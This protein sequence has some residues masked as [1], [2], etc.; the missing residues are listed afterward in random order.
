MILKLGRLAHQQR[1]WFAEGSATW[2]IRL[3]KPHFEKY[4]NNDVSQVFNVLKRLISKLKKSPK[5]T[6]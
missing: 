1:F 4:F 2:Q 5:N 6:L 3:Y